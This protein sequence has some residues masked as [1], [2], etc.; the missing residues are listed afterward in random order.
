MLVMIGTDCTGGYKSNYHTITTATA[1]FFDVVLFH[2]RVTFCFH[3]VFFLGEKFMEYDC[4]RLEAYHLDFCIIKSRSGLKSY[5]LV[6]KKLL[7]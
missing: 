7:H 3:H 4:Q 5:I 6:I 2:L 1:V